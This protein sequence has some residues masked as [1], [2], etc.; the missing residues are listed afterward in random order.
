MCSE[1]DLLWIKIAC[2]QTKG[3]L[4]TGY[5]YSKII[6]PTPKLRTAYWCAYTWVT[7]LYTAEIWLTVVR[8]TIKQ[9]IN[10]SLLILYKDIKTFV[11]TLL[12]AEED[13]CEPNPC[14]NGGRCVAH[15]FGGGFD[16][17]CPLGFRGTTCLGR[18]SKNIITLSFPIRKM[19][20]VNT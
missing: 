20:I 19:A 7:W 13:E 9:K 3:R 16:C 11:S 10:I 2:V 1:L 15:Y 17:E 8:T 18:F 4:C 6:K 12:G 5:E 14:Q